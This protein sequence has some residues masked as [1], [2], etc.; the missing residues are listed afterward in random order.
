LRRSVEL[1]DRLKVPFPDEL[2]QLLATLEK[3]AAE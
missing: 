1:A 2:R 3:L